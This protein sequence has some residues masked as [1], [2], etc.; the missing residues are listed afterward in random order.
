M[1]FT[2]IQNH[3]SKTV[4]GHFITVKGAEARLGPFEMTKR[5]QRRIDGKDKNGG[6][7]QFFYAQW[8]I[9]FVGE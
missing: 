3:T 7:W 5:T 2:A 9:V 8:Q 4:E 6:L 1:K